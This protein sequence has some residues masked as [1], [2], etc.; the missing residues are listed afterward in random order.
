MKKSTLMLCLLLFSLS[1]AWPPL[2]KPYT[3]VE[4]DGA[5]YN[6][7]PIDLYGQGEFLGYAAPTVADLNGDGLWDLLTGIFDKGSLLY[8]E[9]IGTQKS[10]QFDSFEFIQTESGNLTVTP[11]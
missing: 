3:K 7:L 6:Q 1:L 5:P 10:P 8:F 2:F 4:I 9:N 11:T